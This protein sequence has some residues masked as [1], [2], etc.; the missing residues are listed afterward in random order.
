MGGSKSDTLDTGGCAPGR[1]A[2][3]MSLTDL[4]FFFLFPAGSEQGGCGPRLP[5]WAHHTAAAPLFGLDQPCI[6]PVQQVFCLGPDVAQDGQPDADG[7]PDHI[8]TTDGAGFPPRVFVA[9][10]PLVT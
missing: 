7:D 8:R 10:A 4:G 5:R 1:L 6:R 3:C 9:K 2:S